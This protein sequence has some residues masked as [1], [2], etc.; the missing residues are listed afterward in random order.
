MTIHNEKVR[1]L[2]GRARDVGAE[3]PPVAAAA[4][5]VDVG[6]EVSGLRP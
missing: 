6:W 3:L 4:S 5:L 1:Q 2:L